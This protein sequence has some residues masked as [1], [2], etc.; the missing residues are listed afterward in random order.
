MTGKKK[1]FGNSFLINIQF[2]TNLT[3]D[4]LLPTVSQKQKKSLR[5][6]NKT[7]INADFFVCQKTG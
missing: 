1:S 5:N 3:A 4:L 2:C 6:E 7:L